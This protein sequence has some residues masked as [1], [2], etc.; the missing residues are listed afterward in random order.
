[1]PSWTHSHWLGLALTLAAL[2]SVCGVDLFNPD[3]ST[4]E[5]RA[6]QMSTQPGYPGPSVTN[7]AR[8][9][10]AAAR[11]EMRDLI[12]Q[13]A[14]EL[15][16]PMPTLTDE[17]YLDYSKT[18]N[19]RRGEEVLFG[20]RARAARLGLAECLEDQGRF[21]PAFEETIRS[22]CAE[23]AWVMPAHD[24]ALDNFSGRLVTIDLAAA[25]WAW[26]L[27]SI[28]STLGPRL[29]PPTRHR[30]R[31]ELERR[32]F[33]PYRR[34]LAGEQPQYWLLVDNNWNAV[35]L[36][37]VTG[38]ALA[39]LDDPKTRAWFVMAAE[40]YSHYFLSGFT[41]D[42]YCGEGVSYWNYGFGHFA[43]LTEMI[44]QT[45]GGQLDLLDQPNVVQPAAYGLQ[46]EI[47]HGVC[48]AFADC[49]VDA[50]PAPRLTSF[51]RRRFGVN[52]PTV[53]QPS[54]PRSGFV[55]A[56]ADLFS[57]PAPPVKKSASL[58]GP[59]PLRTWFPDGGVL[60]CR[61]DG[62]G[63]GRMGVAILGGH[64]AEHH[65]HNDVGTFTVVVGNE[66]LLPDI[67]AEVYT[68]R[69]FSNRRYESQALNSFG[70]AV[71]VVGGQLQRGGREAAAKILETEFRNEEDTLT[72]DIR[73]AYDLPTLEK[74]TRTFVYSRRG[75]TS[76]TVRDSF[77]FSQP[78][79]F[80]TALLTFGEW[81]RLGPTTLKIR[82][83]R[84]SARVDITPPAGTTLDV[85][86]TE[87]QEDLTA[88]RPAT[89]I[90]LR[91]VP[92]IAQGDLAL[93][94]VPELTP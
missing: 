10:A 55:S 84:E 43:E 31:A 80:E 39:A 21:L 69:T 60:I 73:A 44:R 70:H 91:L 59:D 37:G 12:A 13:A 49:P 57:E 67:G 82:G 40:K 78:E 24:G 25:M 3:P 71:P 4:L 35:C 15:N 87:I 11:S 61:P 46:I 77:A 27:A 33:A 88:K 75:S 28:D 45:T 94:V 20:R 1:M 6:S 64:N 30:I 23:R 62:E 85:A 17:L 51:L 54:S 65:N 90:R 86:S 7:R 72:L 5:T 29:S 76:F 48:P 16:A 68:K 74:L 22:I 38:A 56:L 26:D 58:P 92:P 41:P 8:W 14:Q 93:T 2:P 53:A 34:M 32:V 50:R 47:I 52:S 81:T 66:P 9:T 36:A 19:R 83:Q 79:T 18:G 42:G 89:R 63:R